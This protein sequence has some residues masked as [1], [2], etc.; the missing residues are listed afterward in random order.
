MRLQAH[1]L[2]DGGVGRVRD[3]SNPVLDGAGA[4][5][6]GLGGEANH[7]NHSETA[8]LDLPGLHDSHLLGGAAHVEGVEPLATGVADLLAGAGELLTEDGVRAD[9]A[10]VLH[11]HPA[12]DL[13]PVH[14]DH[15][16]PEEGEAVGDGAVHLLASL[17][18]QGEVA[19]A[20]HGGSV[21]QEDAGSA[22]HSPAAVHQLSLRHPL[23][24]LGVGA[25][26]K[27]VEAVVA[28]GGAIEVS[29]ARVAGEPH[30][31]GGGGHSHHAGGLGGRSAG[32]RADLL[33]LDHAGA[34]GKR[35]GASDGSHCVMWWGVGWGVVEGG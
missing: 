2:E 30:G 3:V 24:H 10:G 19:S 27:G 11:V 6:E 22:E 31:A 16:H 34:G 9:G 29:G 1:G 5:H 13:N 23:G 28:G 18:P 7:G 35:H 25:E 14:E 4:S 32:S 12:A 8:V 15:L 20:S 33:A 17:E 21:G 26:A